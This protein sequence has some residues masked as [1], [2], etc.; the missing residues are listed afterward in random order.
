MDPRLTNACPINYTSLRISA[1]RSLQDTG[2]FNCPGLRGNTNFLRIGKSVLPIA[3]GFMF[4]G[5]P[6]STNTLD[7][8]NAWTV[9]T[10]L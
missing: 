7:S 8:K 1:F 6:W 3:G 10:W 5:A 2:F 4:C 9:A